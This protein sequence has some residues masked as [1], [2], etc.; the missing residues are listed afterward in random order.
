MAQRGVDSNHFPRQPGPRGASHPCGGGYGFRHGGPVVVDVI[1]ELV[2]DGL[3]W[4]P[5]VGCERSAVPFVV[6]LVGQS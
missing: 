6:A 3:C 5:R 2:L 1:F 4:Q